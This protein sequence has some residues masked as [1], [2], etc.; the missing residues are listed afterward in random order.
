MNTY[1][2]PLYF[3]HAMHIGAANASVGIEE[4]QDF[5]HSDTLWA[6]ICNHWAVLGEV[7]GVSFDKFLDSFKNGKP[8]FRISSAFPLTK[9]GREF[10]L[11]KPLSVPF[12]FSH[13][14]PDRDYEIQ[15][16]GKTVKKTRFITLN[17]FKN[18]VEFSANNVSDVGEKPRGISNG[19]VRPHNTLDRVSMASQIFHAGITYFESYGKNRA[20]LYFILKTDQSVKKALEKILEIIYEIGAIG[21]D[22]SIGLGALLEKPILL[23]L[24]EVPKEW[25]NILNNTSDTNA[26]CLLS[27]CYPKEDEPLQDATIAYNFVLRKGWTGSL[28]VGAQVKRQTI[29]MFSEGSVFKKELEGKLVD[30]TP[31][32]T[33]KWQGLHNVYRYGYAFS[34]PL[35]VNLED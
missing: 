25:D 8:L 16:Y 27:L 13:V 33:P 9:S 30:I 6:A 20:G 14:N 32:N 22:R 19:T 29:S 1:I 26:S 17:A 23:E 34:V 3:K 7:E 15:E 18:W 4:A 35:K 31:Q 5:I 11:P 12:S 28:S 2:V 24:K 10:W 21:G